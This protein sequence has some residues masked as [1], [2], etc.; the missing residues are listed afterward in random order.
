MFDAS[1][2]TTS[3]LPTDVIPTPIQKV[4]VHK[5]NKTMLAFN[6]SAQSQATDDVKK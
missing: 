2:M 4:R 1:K 3:K 5:G 6:M